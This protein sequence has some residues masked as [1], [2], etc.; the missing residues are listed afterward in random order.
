MI[1]AIQLGEVSALITTSIPQLC[2]CGLSAF[3][4]HIKLGTGIL[5]CCLLGPM[6]FRNWVS[7]R[8]GVGGVSALDPPLPRV[9][10]SEVR[11]FQ[12]RLFLLI[13]AR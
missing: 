11:P 8:G 12:C 6:G 4:D 3:T 10:L 1:S 9:I 13:L 2:Y 7:V 5:E